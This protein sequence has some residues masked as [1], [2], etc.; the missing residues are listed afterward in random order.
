MNFVKGVIRDISKRRRRASP[1]EESPP[2]AKPKKKSFN[3]GKIKFT[4]KKKRPVEEEPQMNFNFRNQAEAIDSGYDDKYQ[5][6]KRRLKEFKK[7]WNQFESNIH[8]LAYS[9]QTQGLAA[10]RSDIK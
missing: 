9:D 7:Q 3:L 6:A 5:L 2:R 10:A 8:V 4:R 1:S